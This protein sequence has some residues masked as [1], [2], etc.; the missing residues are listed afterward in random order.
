MEEP[1]PVGAGLLPGNDFLQID[2]VSTLAT[3]STSVRSIAPHLSSGRLMIGKVNDLEAWTLL[4]FAGIPDTL[5]GKALVGVDVV[6]RAQYH[7]GDSLAPY[8]MAAHRVLRSWGVDSLTI[9]SVQ[10]A[11]FAEVNPMA[12]TDFGSVHDTA[13]IAFSLDTAVVRG[14]IQSVGDTVTSNFG[15]LLRP[16]G[17]GVVKGFGSFA[18]L[19]EQNQPTL[20]IRLARTGSAVVDT[21]LISAGTFR[22][23]AT[24]TDRGWG[25]DKE[26]IYVQNGVSYR[27]SLSFDAV[28]LL[29]ARAAVHQAILELTLDA[30]ASQRN[31]YTRD[32]VYAY[33]VDEKGNASGSFYALSQAA[34]RDG[35]RIFRLLITPFVQQWVRGGTY[36]QTVIIAGL[37]ESTAVDRLVFHGSGAPAGLQPR[38][39]LSYSPVQ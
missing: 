31:S 17:F 11:G 35:N 1:N 30:P 26:R 9:D 39:K 29:P 22:T 18:E 16:S 2:S 20:R 14:W 13:F 12:S 5:K 32:S 36:P 4:L 21:V 33:F 19:E 27:G 6:L 37:E 15:M 25:I 34:D 10:A 38:L 24:I 3:S 28:K 23:V 8:S 7:F